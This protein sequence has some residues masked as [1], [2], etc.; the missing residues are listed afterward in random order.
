MVVLQRVMAGFCT[1]RSGDDIENMLAGQMLPADVWG[2]TVSATIAY[3]RGELAEAQG[4]LNQ[5]VSSTEGQVPFPAVVLNGQCLAEQARYR[6]LHMF[7]QEWLP[8][9]EALSSWA[10]ERAPS[11]PMN[12][13]MRAAGAAAT[14]M[15]HAEFIAMKHQGYIMLTLPACD[16][17]NGLTAARNNEVECTEVWI[18]RIAYPVE[19]LSRVFTTR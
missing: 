3:V 8:Q 1:R 11:G 6:E 17:I 5:I 14:C 13:G 19:F 4:I 2:R 18:A 15:H 9:F 10:Q 12:P 16:W 7:C